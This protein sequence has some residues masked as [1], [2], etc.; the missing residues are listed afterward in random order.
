MRATISDKY[1][2]ISGTVCDP[3]FFA[4]E[5]EWCIMIEDTEAAEEIIHALEIFIMESDRNWP[6]CPKGEA[7][8]SEGE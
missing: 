2:V 1:P 6:R 4:N 7:T 8:S 3:A 5:F